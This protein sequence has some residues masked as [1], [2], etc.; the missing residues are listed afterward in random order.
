MS[1][2]QFPERS[3]RSYLP[4]SVAATATVLA[5]PLAILWTSTQ[6]DYIEI[7]LAVTALAAV[8]FAVLGT[9]VGSR[10]WEQTDAAGDIS[11]SELMLWSWY[12][13]SQADERL[14]E[15]R[16]HS[17]AVDASPEQQL[18]LLHELSDTLETKDPYTRGHSARV[19]RHAL[20]IASAMGLSLKEIDCLRKAASLHDVGKMRIPNRVLHKNGR[21]N[22]DERA[23][24]EE[25]PVLGSL[26][27]ATLGDEQIV[28]TVRHHHERWDGKGYPDG[29]SGS[30]IPLFARIIAVA[31]TFDAITS[32]RS[33]RAGSSRQKAI[34]VLRAEAGSQFDRQVVE[35]FLTTLPDRRSALTAALLFAPELIWGRLSQ[36]LRSFGDGALAPA[37]GAVGTVIVLGSATF[38]GSAIDRGGEGASK[39]G[40]RP[41]AVAAVAA[42]ALDQADAAGEAGATNEARVLGTRI[43]KREAR[44]TAQRKQAQSAK[45]KQAQ[46]EGGSRRTSSPTG[47]TSS[48]STT[49]EQDAKASAPVA[50]KDS[51]TTQD[52]SVN[53]PATVPEI[54]DEIHDPKKRKG[55]DCSE[56]GKTS[57]GFDLHC[58]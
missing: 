18:E 9:A 5:I 20:K 51:A 35:V 50:A 15:F 28:A 12:R 26:M 1:V 42:I 19:E 55:E 17:A 49:Q 27:V 54:L 48:G 43:H 36:W 52:T 25:H 29:V 22:D 39:S 57:K 58:N 33:Y 23:L 16:I 30:Q 56:L 6:I 14:A 4:H 53:Q 10:L 34:D 32:T 21:L 24:I 11:F 2:A 44:K 31:D 46:Q 45:R 37:V 41:N 40:G 8:A 47:S 13:L 38:V 3:I 7:P